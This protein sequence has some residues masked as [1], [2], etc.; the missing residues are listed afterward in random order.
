MGEWSPGKE[1]GTL[2]GTLWNKGPGSM[3]SGAIRHSSRLPRINWLPVPF[4][5][6]PERHTYVH[7]CGTLW[8]HL[9][10]NREHVLYFPSGNNFHAFGP[11]ELSLPPRHN[12]DASW[13]FPPTWY[14]VF[15]ECS[16]LGQAFHFVP[17]FRGSRYKT[18]VYGWPTLANQAF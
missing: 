12:N 11:R 5:T 1:L 15:H 17:Q 16:T 3:K 14:I 6:M 18:L 8:E 2:C 7:R 10:W 9:T 13:P 4:S